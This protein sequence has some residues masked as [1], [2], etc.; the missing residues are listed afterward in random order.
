ML[1]NLNAF[2]FNEKENLEKNFYNNGNEN[3]FLLNNKFIDKDDFDSLCEFETQNM[4]KK[5][6]T[7]TR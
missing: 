1:L 7:R 4:A 3:S 6:K 2:E 5:K